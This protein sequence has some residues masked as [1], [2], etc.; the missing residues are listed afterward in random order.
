[1]GAPHIGRDGAARRREGPRKPRATASYSP[2]PR[3]SRSNASRCCTS[4]AAP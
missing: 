3:S 1:M 4:S 2:T